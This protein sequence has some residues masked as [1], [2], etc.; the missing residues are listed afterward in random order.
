MTPRIVSWRSGRQG[1]T[2]RW[3]LV[4]GAV[5]LCGQPVPTDPRRVTEIA[6][7]AL[8]LEALCR[9]CLVIYSK[10]VQPA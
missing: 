8:T 4:D 2:P 5:S 7:E 3:H 6:V 9:H 10:G 1:F